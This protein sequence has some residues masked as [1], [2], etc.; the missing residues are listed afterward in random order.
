MAFAETRGS[1]RRVLAHFGAVD[2]L[3]AEAVQPGDCLGIISATWVLSASATVAQPLLVAGVKGEA[4]ETIQ[5]YV[6][7][8]VE[9]ITTAANV[10][11]VGE[12]AALADNGSYQAAGIGLP[13]V[14]YVVGVGSDSLTA[15]LFVLPSAA[16][17][18]VVRA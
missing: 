4:A 9:V 12:K 13:D 5:G 17:L 14:G 6:G 11:T 10:A 7:A 16:Q 1:G 18:T 15:I 2:V 3:L 8:I